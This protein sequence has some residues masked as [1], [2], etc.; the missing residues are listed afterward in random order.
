MPFKMPEKTKETYRGLAVITKAKKDDTRYFKVVLEVGKDEDKKLIE[1]Y[2][3]PE[4]CPSYLNAGRWRI[5]LSQDKQTVF[6]AVPS[7]AVVK[8]QFDGIWH[9][10]GEEPT[11]TTKQ[12]QYGP[13]LVFTWNW[14]SV[15]ENYPG[16]TA[17]QELSYNFEPIP[18]GESK[19]HYIAGYTTSKVK[20][21]RTA[22]LDAVL[23][24]SG[25]LGVGEEE[26]PLP[27][28]ENLLP[29]ITKRANIAREEHGVTSLLTFSN[30]WIIAVKPDVGNS[31]WDE[32]DPDYNPEQPKEP[33]ASVPSEEEVEEVETSKDDGI[34]WDED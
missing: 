1:A 14:K 26:K 20:S 31:G 13:Y 10:E 5:T 15:D 17:S 7:D 18:W 27:W 24:S 25:V 33:Q 29:V 4:K 8:A 30:G 21:P 22:M 28:K 34:P 2:V 3:K 11:P 32:D 19:E 23:N 16:M 6:N 12:G 9:R